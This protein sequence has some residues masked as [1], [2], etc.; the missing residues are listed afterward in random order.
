[1]SN[2]NSIFKKN[3]STILNNGWCSNRYDHDHNQSQGWVKKCFRNFQKNGYS[4]ELYRTLLS[5]SIQFICWALMF[6]WQASKARAIQLIHRR[7][8]KASPSSSSPRR[9]GEKSKVNSLPE[10]F[11][12][13]ICSLILHHT[14]N[15]CVFFGRNT[16]RSVVVGLCTLGRYMAS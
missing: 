16:S 1:M 11:L 4:I 12:F 3:I 7:G 8:R 2:Y 15:I 10:V 5:V 6:G 13:P 14:S 9:E